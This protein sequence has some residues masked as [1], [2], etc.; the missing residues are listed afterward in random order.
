[1]TAPVKISVVQSE[2]SVAYNPDR[3]GTWDLPRIRAAAGADL[4]AALALIGR[5]A[6]EKPDLIVTIEALNQTIPCHDLRYDLAAESEPLDGPLM[7]R[8]AGLARSGRT[9]IAAGLMTRREGRVYNS[10]V[11]FGRDGRMAGLYDKVHLPV[12]EVRV[13]AGSSFPVF[14]T[15]FGCL[16]LLV[17][18]DM[19]YPEAPRILTL[20]GA[21]LIACPTWGW[22]NI[23]G[24]S[25]AYENGVTLAVAMGAMAGQE[26]WAGCDPS[27][28]VANTGKILAVAPRLGAHVV[29]AEVD[30][31][32]GPPLQYGCGRFTD[33]KTMRDV[34]LG[35]RRPD[36]YGPLTTRKGE[37]YENPG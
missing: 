11:L 6:A 30:I 28:V 2:R 26:I 12:S 25:R 34:R 7:S 9:Y 15:D 8:L 33:R 17:C 18:W 19:Q 27:C 29:A 10:V 35:L 13:T 3:P 22:E 24:L 16:G 32:S 37:Q 5:A 36:A 14:Q 21:R 4:D 23:Y 1:M 20:A 31:H